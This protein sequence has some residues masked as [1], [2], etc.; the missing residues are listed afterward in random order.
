M[1]LSDFLMARCLETMGNAPGDERQQIDFIH[2][3]DSL[4]G[5]E[6]FLRMLADRYATHPDYLVEWHD[7]AST[8]GPALPRV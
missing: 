1:T 4:P 7:L 5:G 2:W 8:V 6:N 3:C